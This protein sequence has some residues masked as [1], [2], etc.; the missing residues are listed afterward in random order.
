MSVWFLGKEGPWG[1]SLV[2]QWLRIRLPMQR[3]LVQSL[4]E[5]L[6]P[7]MLWGSWAGAP[8][9]DRSLCAATGILHAIT[10]TQWSQTNKEIS[11][12]SKGGSLSGGKELTPWDL[13][14]K[15]SEVAQSCLTLCD[16]MDCSLPGSSVHVIFQARV[17]EWVAIS[18]TRG[19]SH[20][21]GWT[22]VSC[23]AGGFFTI[24]APR[25]AKTLYLAKTRVAPEQHQRAQTVLPPRRG[26]H[27]WAPLVAPPASQWEDTGRSPGHH[28]L[29][30]C[31]GADPGQIRT[32]TRCQQEEC[33]WELPRESTLKVHQA[34]GQVWD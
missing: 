5:E 24:W 18:F 14:G 12:F 33:Y 4:V 29:Q 30:R 19:S 34:H 28:R 11:I 7:H 16:P 25:E 13:P 27:R 9:Q 3:M 20:P 32:G 15:V 23:I 1:T 26:C 21:R 6:R 10:K 17:L 8:Q 31:S 2:V 22:W